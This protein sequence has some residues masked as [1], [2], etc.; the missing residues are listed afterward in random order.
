MT[1]RM[2]E[3]LRKDLVMAHDYEKAKKNVKFMYIVNRCASN[4]FFEIFM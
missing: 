4:I 1:P 2:N 3:H